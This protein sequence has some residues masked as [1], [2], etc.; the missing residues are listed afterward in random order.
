MTVSKNALE[1]THTH[2][3]NNFTVLSITFERQVY[4]VVE[5][6]GS[7]EVCFFTS[8]GHMDRTKVV[9]EL[10]GNGID[11]STAG[12]YNSHV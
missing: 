3:N 1:H 11:Y 5:N 12:K 2:E 10:L 7:V 8:S 9:V 6:E 4:I